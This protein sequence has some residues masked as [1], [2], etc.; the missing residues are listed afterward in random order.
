MSTPDTPD[1]SAKGKVASMVSELPQSERNILKKMTKEKLTAAL[2]VQ[3]RQLAAQQRKIFTDAISAHISKATSKTGGGP[4]KLAFEWDSATELWKPHDGGPQGLIFQVSKQKKSVI[5]PKGLSA[6]V[7]VKL[8]V[9]W[10]WEEKSTGGPALPD[11]RSDFTHEEQEKKRQAQPP[12]K[13]EKTY[14][15]VGGY[16]F[17]IGSGGFV[18]V[19]IGKAPDTFLAPIMVT[20]SEAKFK[21]RAGMLSLVVDEIE[22]R[23]AKSENWS[24]Y[25]TMDAYARDAELALPRSVKKDEPVTVPYPGSKFMLLAQ[26]SAKFW[27]LAILRQ[28]IDGTKEND[29]YWVQPDDEP[30]EKIVGQ[31]G[32][33]CKAGDAPDFANETCKGF[34]LYLLRSGF[35]LRPGG[36]PPA[37]V[38]GGGAQ[39]ELLR[40]RVANMFG[41]QTSQVDQS[42]G[43]FHCRAG[44]WEG[45]RIHYSI[46]FDIVRIHQNFDAARGHLTL[47]LGD[48]AQGNGNFYRYQFNAGFVAPPSK[49]S[50]YAYGQYKLLTGVTPRTMDQFKIA[51]ADGLRDVAATFRGTHNF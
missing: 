12:K 16:E 38:T 23:I 15:T 34:T 5:A 10:G 9:G 36:R 19:R 49:G 45:V 50:D 44:S 35:S 51:V 32:Q 22:Y 31:D 25:K 8:P 41:L 13:V 48:W 7:G 46:G 24:Y 40:W 33:P 17:E 29:E 14:G 47:E 39:H 28:R 42:S 4:P 3:K 2:E 6:A 21:Q 43:Q 27:R 30:H 1:S 37:L 18:S 26:E 11:W 20:D